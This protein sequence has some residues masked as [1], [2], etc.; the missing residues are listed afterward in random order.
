MLKVFPAL[1]DLK[2]TDLSSCITK[3]RILGLGFSDLIG[4]ACGSLPRPGRRL[5]L[6]VK[7]RTQ[8][9]Q[10]WRGW[11]DGSVGVWEGHHW[12][13]STDL[14][15]GFRQRRRLEKLKPKCSGAPARPLEIAPESPPF[16]LVSSSPEDPLSVSVPGEWA[17]RS[18]G[19][20]AKPQAL[21]SGWDTSSSQT[22]GSLLLCVS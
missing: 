4:N 8:G 15:R 20:A 11:C 22:L 1:S 17:V 2:V 10:R 19:C 14:G 13:L 12:E 21:S 18:M 16:Q 6:R 5:C 3:S 9:R 7:C